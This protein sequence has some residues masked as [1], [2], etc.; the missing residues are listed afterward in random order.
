MNEVSLKTIIRE[1]LNK[2]INETNQE[3]LFL[4][5]ERELD[6]IRIASEYTS[7][8]NT[9]MLKIVSAIENEIET[10]EDLAIETNNNNYRKCAEAFRN[11]KEQAVA[12]YKQYLDSE[13]DY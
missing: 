1:A 3:S 9:N 4:R 12:T 7:Q 10:L 8:L 13:Y 6:S 5:L 2:Y 11:L